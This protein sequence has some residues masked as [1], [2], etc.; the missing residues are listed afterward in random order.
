MNLNYLF[1]VAYYDELSKNSGQLSRD[2]VNR[3][4]DALTNQQFDPSEEQITLLGQHFLMKTVY[5]GLLIGMGNPH[6][7]GTTKDAPEIK[8]GFSLDYRTGLPLI[9]G[10]TVK[11]MLRSAFSG[12]PDLVEEFME[13]PL[14]LEEI[15]K[16]EVEIFGPDAETTKKEREG[17]SFFD[18]I[19]VKTSGGRL[20]GLDYITPHKADDPAY[21][22]LQ[23][24]NPICIMKVLPEVQYLFQFQLKDSISKPE[25]TA[26]RKKNCFIK[27]LREVGIG[28]K[29][30]VGYGVLKQV[31]SSDESYYWLVPTAGKAD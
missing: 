1:N 26:D 3:N 6:E 14:S 9:P 15:K 17:D 4:N 19:P 23:S 20:Y 18:A 5:P 27:L 7:S 30:N 12:Y 11:G 2:L 31:K 25:I 13:I 28:G 21:D 29:T 8:V 16:L 10:S 22:G 24:P